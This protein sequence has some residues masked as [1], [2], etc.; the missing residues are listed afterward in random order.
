MERSKGATE[1]DQFWLD[2]EAALTTSGQSAKEYAA[3]KGLSLSA[4][5][6]ARKRLRELGLFAPAAPRRASSRKSFGNKPV[7]FTR[8][9]VTP[10]ACEPRFRVE[11][12]GDVVLE[13]TG[14][15]VPES[16]VGLLERLARPA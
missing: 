8:V 1:R 12:P 4:F 10:E 6:Q 14:G 3:G 5:Y 9:Q 2:H 11:L 7:S 13:W 15:E 16:V